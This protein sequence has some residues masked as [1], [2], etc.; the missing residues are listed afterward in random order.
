MSPLGASPPGDQATVSISVAVEPAVAFEVFTKETDLWWR[1]GLQFR[2]AG[3]HPGVIA[4]E[5]GEG[6]RLFESF[7]TASGPQMFEAG[8]ILA[9]EP[10]TRLLFE[11]RAA[12]FAS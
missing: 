2:V 6:G 3:R 12:N 4:F 1:R 7:E 8:R 9:W 10:P 5:P 11:W